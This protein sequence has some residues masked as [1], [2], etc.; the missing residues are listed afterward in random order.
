[1]STRGISSSH[2]TFIVSLAAFTAQVLAHNES[3]VNDMRA[4]DALVGAMRALAEDA[5]AFARE[6]QLTHKLSVTISR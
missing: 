2:E 5:G 4:N 6:Q 3:N 1:M